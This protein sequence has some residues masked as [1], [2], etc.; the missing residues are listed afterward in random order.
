MEVRSG[1]SDEEVVYNVH[2]SY[3]IEQDKFE[4][5]VSD[6]NFVEVKLLCQVPPTV[7]QALCDVMR[8]VAEYEA[9]GYLA[10]RGTPDKKPLTVKEFSDQAGVQSMEQEDDEEIGLR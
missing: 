4:F 9:G 3:D 7:M 2:A 5:S 8:N 6:A 10:Y 1:E